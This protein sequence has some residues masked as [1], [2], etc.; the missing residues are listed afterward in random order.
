MLSSYLVQVVLVRLDSIHILLII[1]FFSR[2]FLLIRL[3]FGSFII[4][5]LKVGH[6]LVSLLQS[7]LHESLPSLECKLGYLEQSILIQTVVPIVLTLLN[8]A[9]VL[10]EL[11]EVLAESIPSLRQHVHGL[12]SVVQIEVSSATPSYDVAATCVVQVILPYAFLK[13][14]VVSRVTHQQVLIIRR[15]HV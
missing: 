1:R 11:H 4:S 14:R 2:L 3:V 12:L 10:D 5:F 13:V 15:R 6:K 9:L 7:L 8:L